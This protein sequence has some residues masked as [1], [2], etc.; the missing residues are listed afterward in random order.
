VVGGRKK[1]PQQ[2]CIVT[3]ELPT[4]L[5]GSNPKKN[6]DSVALPLEAT[7]DF[8]FWSWCSHHVEILKVPKNLW[9]LVCKNLR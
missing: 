7:P 6:E 9:L 3:E 1:Y 2:Q 4:M 8:K 5:I